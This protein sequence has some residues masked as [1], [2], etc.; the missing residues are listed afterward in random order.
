MRKYDLGEA[1]NTEKNH[2][3]FQHILMIYIDNEADRYETSGPLQICEVQSL[4]LGG[5]LPYNRSNVDMD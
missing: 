5:F 4:C 1:A 3:D 2:C